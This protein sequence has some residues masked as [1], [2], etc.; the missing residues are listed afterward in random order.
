[1]FAQAAG[2]V[3][4]DLLDDQN[5]LNEQNLEAAS[6]IMVFAAT[7]HVSEMADVLVDVISEES[8]KDKTEKQRAKIMHSSL[9]ALFSLEAD[10]KVNNAISRFIDS[11]NFP[12]NLI[13]W[14][15]S[16]LLYRDPSRVR[17]LVE[18]YSERCVDVR[19]SWRQAKEDDRSDAKFVMNEWLIAVTEANPD[20]QTLEKARQ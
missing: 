9:G 11:S 15:T 19:D 18:K 17:E 13:F 6:G 2:D 4:V 10:P 20:K 1:M 7:A 12:K 14:A 3:I 16:Q 5:G 8:L